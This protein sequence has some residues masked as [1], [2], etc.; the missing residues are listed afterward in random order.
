MAHEH[1]HEDAHD[2]DGGHGHSHGTVDPTLFKS[3]SATESGIR[4]VKWSLVVLGAT[5][6]FQLVIVFMTGSVALLSDTVHNFGD[7]STA[8]PL[9]I[10]FALMRRKP[11]G[12]FT[13][14]YGR[15]E[16]LAGLIVLLLILAS[17]VV[18]A[19][20]S[21]DRLFNPRDIEFPWILMAAGFIGFVGNEAVAMIR[22]R[23]GRRIGSTA[24]VADGYHA[25]TDGLTSLAV[26]AAATGALVGFSLL[27][28]IIGI[29]ISAMILKLLV[30]AAKP[31]FT[32]LLD[33]VEPETV[34]QIRATTMMYAEVISVSD[35]RARWSGHE[36]YADLSIG[37]RSGLEVSDGHGV[38]AKVEHALLEAIPHLARVMVHVD[39][40]TSPGRSFHH[41]DAHEYG[42]P[43]VTTP[44]RTHIRLPRR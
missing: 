1:E 29:V 36:L 27:D 5:A 13:Y 8:I 24:L 35:I 22:I 25:R 20:T 38:A 44:R 41:R 15:V 4:A 34:E 39:P 40:E 43:N 28:P 16:D 9:W 18:A 37:V 17:A 7:A 32:H 10:A 12:R 23:V 42:E 26:V 31:V 30:T 21:I 3:V 2:H 19:Y 14:G 6:I 33:G 11:G